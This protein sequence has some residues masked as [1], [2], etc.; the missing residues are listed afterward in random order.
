M[1]PVSV[2][3]R[4]KYPRRFAKP[5]TECIAR[6]GECIRRA[7]K[8]LPVRTSIS[9]CP[10][11]VTATRLEDG[12]R[13]IC[14][15][16]PEKPFLA[17]DHGDVTFSGAPVDPC[18][19][20]GLSFSSHPFSDSEMEIMD[21][22]MPHLEP[23]LDDTT[24][25]F[26]NT[27]TLIDW[28]VGMDEHDERFYSAEIHPMIF[29]EIPHLALGSGDLVCDPACGTG[30]LIRELRM[31]RPDLCFVASDL[32]A[33]RV[34][35]ARRYNPG[36]QVH[37]GDAQDMAY[38]KPASVSLFLLCGLLN[39]QVVTRE[40]GV[41]ILREIREKAKHHAYVLITGKT[42]PLFSSAELRRSGL[43]SVLATKWSHFRFCPFSLCLTG[44]EE[45]C[46]GGAGR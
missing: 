38:L 34:K 12:V 4:S 10:G 21:E 23:F 29:S 22:A 42:L 7:R 41:R 43:F 32:A 46:S 15:S 30:V 2:A 11:S 6:A 16:D 5:E 25:F 1:K 24:F 40:Q 26:G 18:K 45:P 9:V 19:K 20:V 3:V 14:I 17:I 36:V 13:F 37:V 39:D 8:R 31:R 35:T 28:S 33:A 44:V 27:E